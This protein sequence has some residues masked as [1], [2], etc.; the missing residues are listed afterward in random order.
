MASTPV[1]TI[2]LLTPQGWK[3]E[4]ARLV[5]P[6]WTLNPQSGHKQSSTVAVASTILRR[7]SGKEF[8]L[9]THL[10][11]KY[12]KSVHSAH[13]NIHCPKRDNDVAIRLS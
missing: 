6:Y 13:H 2:H 1:I 3:A 12:L 7:H 8:L 5:D 9:P 10:E 11:C 4:L